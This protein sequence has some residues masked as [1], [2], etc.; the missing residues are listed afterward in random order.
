MSGIQLKEAK[1][2]RMMRVGELA[3]FFRVMA[4][5]SLLVTQLWGQQ[6]IRP[7]RPITV[8]DVVAM[9]RLEDTSFIS[10]NMS[11]AHFSPDGRRFVVVIRKGNLQRKTNDFSLLLYSTADALHSLKP[12]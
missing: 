8:A 6:D 11:I 5:F 3:L 1:S 2:E 7:Q 9:T 12:D 10:G 4:S